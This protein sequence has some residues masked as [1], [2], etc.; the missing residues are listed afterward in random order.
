MARKTKS[1]AQKA[2]EARNHALR[3]EA[4]KRRRAKAT[5]GRRALKANIAAMKKLGKQ[6]RAERAAA[7][8]ERN[9]A[10]AAAAAEAKAARIEAH[11]A[12]N[13]NRKAN[14]AA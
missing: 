13:E 12:A 10:T 6:V 4:N 3:I 5:A 1:D 11:Q 14:K 8:A 2:H 7:H 9:A